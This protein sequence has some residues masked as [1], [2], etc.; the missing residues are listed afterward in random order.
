MKEYKDY[1]IA[2]PAIIISSENY[3]VVQVKKNI[4]EYTLGDWINKPIVPIQR[5]IVI[6][7]TKSA[8]KKP[9]AVKPN[10]QEQDPNNM[11][12]PAFK[13]KQ[14]SASD[15]PMD[16]DPTDSNLDNASPKSANPGFPKKP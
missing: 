10:E 3:K 15:P 9:E 12:A 11:Q 6:P 8:G 1:K 4:D 16:I 14:N 2:N 7:E 13:G 5:N